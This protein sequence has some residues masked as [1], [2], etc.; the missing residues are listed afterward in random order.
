MDEIAEFLGSLGH[1]TWL[2]LGLLLIIAEPF[3]PGTYIMW[4]GVGA[5]LTGCVYWLFDGLS[6]EMQLLVFSLGSFV[7]VLLGIFVYD[8]LLGPNREKEYKVGSGAQRFIGKTYIVSETIQNG[9]GKIA[10]G[11]TV[12]LA[13][14]KKKIAKGSEVVVVGVDGTQLLV[15]EKE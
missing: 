10:V 13:R 5:I 8:K 12:W 3:I 11:D 15:E 2:C 1:W 4:F 14:S 7:S 9:K 6:I